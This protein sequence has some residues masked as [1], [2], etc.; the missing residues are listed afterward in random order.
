MTENKFIKCGAI[1]W[2]WTF[3]AVLML[4]LPNVL[5]ACTSEPTSDAP[6]TTRLTSTEDAAQNPPAVTSDVI[7][8]AVEQLGSDSMATFDSTYDDTRPAGSGHVLNVGEGQ[9]YATPQE[10]YKASQ[11]GDTIVIHSG[12]Y[13]F[14]GNEYHTRYDADAPILVSHDI[15]IVGLGDVTFDIGDVAKGAL[16]TEGNSVDADLY[17]ENITFQGAHNRDFNGAGIRH[18]DGNLTV[19]NSDFIG[20]HNGILGGGDSGDIVKIVDSR[21]HNNGEGDGKS[22]AVYVN[23]GDQLIVENSEFTGTNEGHHVKSLAEY[24]KVTDSILG[25]GNDTASMAVDVTGGGDLT[26]ERNKIVQSSN[27]DNGNIIYYSDYRGEKTGH[28]E[29]L[30]NEIINYRDQAIVVSV[31]LTDRPTTTIDLRGNSI[32]SVAGNFKVS[33]AKY[34]SND[35]T[36]NG[37][38]LPSGTFDADWP[39][40][41][42]I[43]PNSLTDVPMPMLENTWPS[44]SGVYVMAG[45]GDHTLRGTDNRDVFEAQ[46]KGTKTMIGGD[47]DDVYL[48][49]GQSEIREEANAGRDWVVMNK[50]GNA[51]I[52]PDHVEGF[53]H[54]VQDAYR[55]GVLGNAQDNVFIGAVG[56]NNTFRGKGG[57]DLMFG[58]EGA[59]NHFFGGDGTDRYVVLGERADYEIKVDEYTGDISLTHPDGTEDVLEADVEE[60]AFRDTVVTTADLAGGNKEDE[61]SGSTDGGSDGHDSSQND[62]TTQS[63]GDNDS[64]YDFISRFPTQM[65]VPE[66]EAPASLPVWDEAVSWV[67]DNGVYL[68]SGWG[69]A[70]L[71]GTDGRDVLEALSRGTKT[72]IGGL[73][74]DIYLDFG[75]EQILESAGEGYDWVV[76]NKGGWHYQLP[77]NV[78]GFYV[79]SQDAFHERIDGN[80][81]N[82]V[83]VGAS[84]G[85]NKFIGAE[86]DDIMYGGGA[87]GNIFFGGQGVDTFVLSGH[88]DEYEIETVTL[89][90]D[91]HHY[92]VTYENGGAD[93][94][95]GDVEFLQFSDGMLDLAT[96]T[97][98][99][100]DSATDDVNSGEPSTA[101]AVDDQSTTTYG[102]T[103]QIDVLG[104]DTDVTSLTD[105]SAPAAGTAWIG[106]D[107]GLY[108]RADAGVVGSDSFS[109]K[110]VGSDGGEVSANVTVQVE[111]EKIFNGDL[112]SYGGQD[113]DAGVTLKDDGTRIDLDGNTWQLSQFQYEVTPD[114]VLKLDFKAVQLGEIQGVGVDADGEWNNGNEL[115]FAL[116]GSQTNVAGWDSFN[117]DYHGQASAEWATVEIALG[118]HYQ[119]QIKN[120]AFLNDQDVIDPT[121]TAAFQNLVMYEAETAQ[122]ETAEP[123]SGG[124]FVFNQSNFGSYGGDQDVNGQVKVSND[125]SQVELSGN[126][127]K[128]TDIDYDV[129]DQTILS[130]EFKSDAIGELHGIGVEKDNTWDNGNDVAFIVAGTQNDVGDRSSLNFDYHDDDTVN[131]QSYEVALGDYIDGTV[132]GLTF[133]ND[134]DQS[135]ALPSSMFR[136]VELT[137]A[138]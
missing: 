67:G 92:N 104:N 72:M 4:C 44:E 65:T 138:V 137:E 126:G 47:G 120:L 103:T 41:D 84:G 89:S 95:H 98:Q 49:W 91:V 5:T 111:P 113:E 80:K 1:L 31:D 10:A 108:Y 100:S 39:V 38:T 118:D 15:N 110:A 6:S 112:L 22:H 54:H 48:A 12:T 2:R 51:Y 130:F 133:V 82:N 25:D 14:S 74:N 42:R 55:D 73:G 24:T 86:G 117:Y 19:V 59:G 50:T 122:T 34:T 119:G 62:D 121:A 52:M 90:G 88:R 46:Q 75:Q 94:V 83:F 106:D 136:N 128:K 37:Q 16:V 87:S 127:W 109:Y 8:A 3:L 69:D 70:Q 29:L 97:W 81:E 124:G 79:A 96:Q 105:V 26:L 36:L 129:T 57:D 85:Q 53:A 102:R 132:S 123:S 35:N 23:G 30:N 134:D 43:L 107:G 78:E 13:S 131:W 58:G 28:I 20:N 77:D 66:L 45:W 93:E 125:G 114:T 68:S 18:Q 115:A 56:G 63:S 76:V 7:A 32:E 17:V 101:K 64:S 60:I 27:V 116:A 9:Q 33:D 40:A 135:G 21:F 11:P 71:Q 61:G 99:A